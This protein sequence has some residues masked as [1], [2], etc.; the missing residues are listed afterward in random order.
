MR[1]LETV[2]RWTGDGWKDRPRVLVQVE[3]VGKA[4]IY[5]RYRESKPLPDGPTLERG[6][7]TGVVY[8]PLEGYEVIRI[9]NAPDRT[10]QGRQITAHEQYPTAAAFGQ[11][12][13]FCLDLDRAKGILKR[14]VQSITAP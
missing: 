9:R 13:K 10:W 8:G 2:I 14:W 5:A 7:R 12:G 4:A 3:R 1:T 6:T 11:Y